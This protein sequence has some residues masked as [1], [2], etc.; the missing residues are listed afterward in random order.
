MLQFGADVL[1]IGVNLLQI[2]ATITSRDNY[3]KSPCTKNEVSH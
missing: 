3:Y 1:Q 2:G